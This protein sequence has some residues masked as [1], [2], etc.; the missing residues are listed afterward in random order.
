M[1]ETELGLGGQA[2]VVR[3]NQRLGTREGTEGLGLGSLVAVHHS[4]YDIDIVT[5]FLRQ[6]PK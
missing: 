1:H 2:R 6:P 3:G 5:G 4:R